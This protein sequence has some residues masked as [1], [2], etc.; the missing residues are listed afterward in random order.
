MAKMKKTG[1]ITA[2]DSKGWEWRTSGK[3][4]VEMTE[5][6]AA[7]RRQQAAEI[8]RE[9]KRTVRGSK[10]SDASNT[11]GNPARYAGGGPVRRGYGKARGC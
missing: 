1:P 3:G 7:I 8:E 11:M 10:A 2:R 5:D 9:T 6:S 4:G